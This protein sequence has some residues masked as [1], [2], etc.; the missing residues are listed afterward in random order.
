MAAGRPSLPIE[1]KRLRGRRP[2]T[3]SGDRPLPKPVV[4]TQ[5]T[6]TPEP[7]AGVGRHGA[8]F[9]RQLW[10]AGPWLSE[11]DTLTMTL[12][13]ENV[14]EREKMRDILAKDG[15]ITGCQGRTR[16]VHPLV[17]ALRELETQIAGTA[18]QLGFSPAARAKLG[19]AMAS[20][21]GPLGQM[22]DRQREHADE[23]ASRRK[24]S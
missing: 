10:D 20:P 22:M 16:V 11:A 23:L 13:L 8:T 21:P 19:I 9:W 18:G 15:M 3:D 2:G 14:I 12:L 1:T 17:K 5:R 7:P 24:P 6:H 4:F